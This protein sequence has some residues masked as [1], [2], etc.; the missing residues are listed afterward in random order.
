MQKLSDQNKRSTPDRRFQ[1]IF[2][3]RD[4][5]GGPINK[6]ADPTSNQWKTSPGIYAKRA[7][8]AEVVEGKSF[9]GTPVCQSCAQEGH[10]SSQCKYW[11][12]CTICSGEFRHNSIWHLK[13]LNR[14]KIANGNQNR[15]QANMPPVGR[16]DNNHQ[17]KWQNKE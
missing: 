13:K 5:R 6:Q 2:G 10:N 16:D 14:E 15:Q 8:L 17:N 1:E 4:R 11:D 3:M 12:Y 9:N 7:T